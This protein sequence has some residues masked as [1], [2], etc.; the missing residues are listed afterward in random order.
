[1]DAAAMGL[2]VNFQD[3]P[4]TILATR[5]FNPGQNLR[6]AGKSD[7]LGVPDPLTPVDLSIEWSGA[8]FYLSSRTNLAGNYWFRVTLPNVLTK[9][10]VAVTVHRP[11][12]SSTTRIPIGIGVAPD[13]L[14]GPEPGIIDKFVRGALVVT[15]VVVGA[16]VLLQFRRGRS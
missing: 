13:P 12:G 10:V 15:A 8:P 2:T 14:P 1:M 4:G 3:P 9:A 6:I 11:L 7:W 16:M 5:R